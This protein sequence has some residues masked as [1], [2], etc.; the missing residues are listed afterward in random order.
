[1]NKQENKT[2]R[3]CTMSETINNSKVLSYR[4]YN[5]SKNLFTTDELASVK[6]E[7]TVKPYIPDGYNVNPVVP[8]KLY[9]E[10]SSRLYVPKCYGLKNF[11][12]PYLVKIEDGVNIDIKFHGNLRDYQEE[13]VRKFMEAANNPCKRGGILNVYCGF[14]KTNLAIYIMCLLKKKTIILCHK[15]FLL[16]QWKERIEV[17]APDA[18][19]G[20][21]KAKVIDIEGKDVV[22]ASLQSVA[23][24]EYEEHIFKD[25]GFLI[26]DESHHLPAEVFSQALRKINCTYSLGLT[27][28]LQRKDGLSKVLKW[29]IGDVVFKA[30]K[31]NDQVKVSML[32]YYDPNPEYSLE[33]KGYGN[34][35]NVSKM[36]NNICDYEP[37]S[38][39]IVDSVKDVL[40]KEPSR[41][42]IILSDRRNHLEKLHGILSNN[43]I[44]CAFYVGGMKQSELKESETKRVILATFH[45][46]SEG[47]DCP[48]LDTLI[49]ASPKSDVIQ[50][51]GRIQRIPQHQRNNVPLVID[52]VDNFSLFAKQ[53]QKRLKYYTSC[54]YDIE[55]DALFVNQK[56]EL[57]GQCFI[58]DD[59]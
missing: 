31:R 35:L 24:K 39:F 40:D 38:K 58:Q 13:P 3:P 36:I 52:I 16:Q 53:A 34:K 2:I 14:G 55:G 29:Y 48:G 12:E 56:V 22:L 27:A 6:N 9:Q 15:D 59:S 7:L 21:I 47:F 43:Q 46:A 51:V 18:K 11:G 5:I 28:T 45:I 23:M 57:K 26:A 49:L 19:I 8:F 1:M 42:V 17:F 33:C 37:R 10:T 25:F 41:R 50:C 44:E 20:L 54:K 32:N 30:T 4:G